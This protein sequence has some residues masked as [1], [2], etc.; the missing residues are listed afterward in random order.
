MPNSTLTTQQIKEF[1][2]PYKFAMDE[3]TT[4]LIIMKEEAAHLLDHNPIEHMKT[5]IKTAESI[6]KKLTRK[7]LPADLTQ[8]K[9]LHDI[10]G[11]RLVCGFK[12]DIYH[13]ARFIE[14]R[15]DMRVVEVKDYI[16][17]SKPN[18]YQSL[19]LIIEVP[20]ELAHRTE[21]IH[22]EVQIR[23]LAMDFWASL[24]HKI[25]YKYER[26]IPAHL[27]E[28]LKRAAVAVEELDQ[29]MESIQDEVVELDES[30]DDI[31]LPR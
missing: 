19:H 23:T 26:E 4:K 16:Q 17:H 5:R 20:V 15:R 6:K 27:K 29:R 18:G 31:F 22:A 2:L 1:L 13:V 30:F 11:V 7:G 28:D 24:E 21:L 14:K 10:V 25:F 3:L 8:A 12:S 9:T